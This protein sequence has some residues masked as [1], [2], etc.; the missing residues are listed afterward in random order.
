[1]TVRRFVWSR[2]LRRRVVERRWRVCNMGGIH[3]E[4]KTDWLPLGD[5]AL[6]AFPARYPTLA[7]HPCRTARIDWDLHQRHLVMEER[8]R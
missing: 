4:E 6:A 3:P 2:L 5:P 7:V 8:G 1:M